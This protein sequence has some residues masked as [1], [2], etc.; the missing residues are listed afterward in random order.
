MIQLD[1]RGIFLGKVGTSARLNGFELLL[2]QS[3][4][5]LIRS[6][7]CDASFSFVVVATSSGHE[8]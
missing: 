5:V 7:G 1:I 6:S 3:A 8:S 2:K 4:A